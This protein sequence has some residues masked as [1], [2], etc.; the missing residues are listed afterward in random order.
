MSSFYLITS[1]WG[2]LPVDNRADF[3]KDA[4]LSSMEFEV[5]HHSAITVMSHHSFHNIISISTVHFNSFLFIM[6]TNESEAQWNGIPMPLKIIGAPVKL[7]WTFAVLLL[8]QLLVSYLF[9]DS[10]S[11]VYYVLIY[12]GPVLFLTSYVVSK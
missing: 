10:L 3:K 4:V 6:S 1:L 12:F 11:L 9:H 7:H 2:Q 5:T 8:S